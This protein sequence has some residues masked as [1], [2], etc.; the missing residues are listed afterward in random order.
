MRTTLDGIIGGGPIAWLI[1]AVGIVG[2]LVMFERLYVIVLRS[3]NNGRPF[4]ERVIQLVRAGKIDDAIKQ[5]AES[6]AALPDIGL[7]ILRSRSQDERAL[8]DVAE[9]ASLMVIPKLTHRIEYLSSLALVAVLLG[10]VGM[11]GG[12]RGAFA[13]AASPDSNGQMW[14]R[15][16]DSLSPVNLGVIVAIVLLIGRAYLMSQARS[17]SGQIHEFSARLVN[18]LIDR[19]D[20]RLGHR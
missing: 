19:P 11:L 14:S 13:A 17:I 7:L 2:V 9:A 5:C 6:T 16:S 12:M 18:A 10:V 3:K 15:L 20:V 1:V 4:I 8:Q